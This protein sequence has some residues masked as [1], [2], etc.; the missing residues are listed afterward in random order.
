VLAISIN[1]SAEK[2]KPLRPPRPPE[3]LKDADGDAIGDKVDN[4]PNEPEDKDLFDD[5]DGCPDVDNDN[6]GLADAVDR[7]PLDAEDK[8]GAKDDDGCPDH[9]NDGDGVADAMD[10]CPNAVEDKDGVLDTDGCPDA[11]N[12]GDG[13]LDTVDKC[14]QEPETINGNN[15]DDGCPD[16]GNALVVLSPDRLETLEAIV[17]NGS[18][19]SR[20][21]LNV[22]GQIGATLRAHPEI[23]R[24]RVTVHVN[25]SSNA[26][27]D[28][29]LTEQRAKVV[30]DWLVEWGI[31]PLRLQGAGFGGTKPL[32]PATQRGA[33]DINDRVELIILERN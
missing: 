28:K 2:L 24:V 1:P 12:D 19:L 6:D 3:P 16:K 13:L 14:P 15:D 7:C 11:D 23:L 5:A 29:S 26:G 21:S 10:K 20:S 17:F 8:D 30:R 18:K 4:C 32:V 22:L 27:A 33:K 25:P 31:D 9:D